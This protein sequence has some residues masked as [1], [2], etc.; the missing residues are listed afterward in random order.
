MN[1][2]RI[3]CK[4]LKHVIQS[5]YQRLSFWPKSPPCTD[6]FISECLCGCMVDYLLLHKYFCHSVLRL[7]AS[8]RKPLALPQ[9]QLGKPGVRDPSLHVWLLACTYTRLFDI[10]CWNKQH[11][12]L[13]F[14]KSTWFSHFFS[15]GVLCFLNPIFWA[16]RAVD[17]ELLWSHHHSETNAG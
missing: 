13:R 7:C 3:K 11:F 17:L 9:S 2:I 12:C 14:P 5:V 8:K 10:L 16:Y 15:S 4:A 1:T 6:W